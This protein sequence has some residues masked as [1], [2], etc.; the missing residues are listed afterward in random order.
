MAI[1][2]REPGKGL[3]VGRDEDVLQGAVEGGVV[4]GDGGRSGGGGVEG[5][6]GGKGVFRYFFRVRSRGGMG[7]EDVERSEIGQDE[8]SAEVDVR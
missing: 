3:G 7:P 1:G 6:V 8:A 4:V 5:Q 2:V